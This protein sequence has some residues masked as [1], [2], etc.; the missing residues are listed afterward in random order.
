MAEWIEILCYNSLEIF[1]LSPLAMAEWI[2]IGKLSS[3]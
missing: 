2:E 1:L 3:H